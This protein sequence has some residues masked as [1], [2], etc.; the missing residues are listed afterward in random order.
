MV[1]TDDGL[2][3]AASR[4]LAG[5]QRERRAQATRKNLRKRLPEVILH[6]CLHST[7]A[8]EDPIVIEG[9]FMALRDVAHDRDR[10]CPR[11]R[12]SHVPRTSKA[13]VNSRGLKGEGE[14]EG[15]QPPGSKEFCGKF[16]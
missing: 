2:K 7:P 5:I 12:S 13:K 14:L 16:D 6:I 3:W 15:V 1:K 11:L 10:F 9:C 8:I 4:A